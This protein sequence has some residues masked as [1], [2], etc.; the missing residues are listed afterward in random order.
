MKAL[1]LATSM[2][3]AGLGAPALAQPGVEMS[4]FHEEELAVREK[5]MDYFWG[6]QRG[7]SEQMARAFDMENGHFKMVRRSDE[8]DEV[9]VFTLAEFAGWADGP[10]ESPNEG[11]IVMVDIVEDQMAFV[12]F[13]LEGETRTF[14]DYFTLYKANDAWAIINK[15]SAV[16]NHAPAE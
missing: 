5:V 10:I 2:M 1:I 12:K 13:E 8:G 14:I 4:V 6:R 3:V 7:D 15:T 11:R 16:F 9:A